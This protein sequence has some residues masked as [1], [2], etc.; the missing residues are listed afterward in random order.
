MPVVVG[1][2]THLELATTMQKTYGKFLAIACAVTF[3][4]GHQLMRD[5]LDKANAAAVVFTTADS[6]LK[7]AADL[8]EHATS[9][10]TDGFAMANADKVQAHAS[11]AILAAETARAVHAANA[12][13]NA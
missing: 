3:L 4:S 6:D 9:E 13:A 1:Y 10:I 7:R 5:N 2:V 12:S 11:A 8:H